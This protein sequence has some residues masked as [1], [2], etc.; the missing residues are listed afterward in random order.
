MNKISI[1]GIEYELIG[2]INTGKREYVFVVNNNKVEYYKKSNMGYV[3]PVSD[4]TLSGN[5][6]G[7]LSE[8]DENV[9]LSHLRD[10]L[11]R[12]FID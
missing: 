10:M 8:L 11:Q 12:D 9:S 6:G 2:E 3:K 5:A 7:S 1:N 4:L